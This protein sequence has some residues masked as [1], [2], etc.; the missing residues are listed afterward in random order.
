MPALGEI[1]YHAVTNRLTLDWKSNLHPSSLSSSSS[2]QGS[3]YPSNEDTEE[4]VARL[5]KSSYRPSAE[6]LYIISEK[7][8]RDVKRGEKRSAPADSMNP[9]SSSSVV[10]A[11]AAPV[12]MQR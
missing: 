1:W 11:A 5:D 9:P 12:V 10:G 7:G 3:D 4:R 8:V 6:A 2:L